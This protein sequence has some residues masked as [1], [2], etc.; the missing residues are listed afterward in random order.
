MLGGLNQ[1]R[2]TDYRLRLTALV[3]ATEFRGGRLDGAA[4]LARFLGTDLRAGYHYLVLDSG[5]VLGLASVARIGREVSP[6][7]AGR[8]RTA[9]GSRPT[10]RKPESAIMG[11]TARRIPPPVFHR[12]KVAEGRFRDPRPEPFRSPTVWTAIVLLP[13]A[14]ASQDIL[15]TLLPSGAPPLADR[16]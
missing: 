13:V 4:S 2:P 10:R 15:N 12:V 1:R 11:F 3:D 8:S 5:E 9:G 7:T 6:T 14:L 16:L